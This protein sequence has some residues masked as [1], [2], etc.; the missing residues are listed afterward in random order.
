MTANSPESSIVQNEPT[1]TDSYSPIFRLWHWG[2]ALAIMALLCTVLISSTLLKPR[3]NAAMIQDKLSEKGVSVT[4]DQ[5]KAV[6]KMLENKVWEW[7]KY[8]GVALAILLLLRIILEFADKRERRLAV[9]LRKSLFLSKA[10]GGNAEAKHSLWVK[11]IY[12]LFYLLLL[13]IVLT[14]LCIIYAND[15]PSLKA[16]KGNLK[17]IH[18]FCMYGIMGFIVLHIGGL[19]RSELTDKPGITAVMIHGGKR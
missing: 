19:L 5:A 10:A 2:S 1:L 6:A 8:I 17:D 3:A 15:F 7:H 18:S 12:V 13:T 11:R 16:I 4:G 9:R 14:G